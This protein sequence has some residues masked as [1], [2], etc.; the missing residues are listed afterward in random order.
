MQK[1]RVALALAASLLAGQALPAPRHDDARGCKPEKG[2]DDGRT[3]EVDCDAGGTIARALARM[4]PGDAL[5]VSGV[6]RENVEIGE[7]LHDVTVDGQGLAS[8]VPPSAALDGVRIYGDQVTIRGFTISG[9]RDVINLRGAMGTTIDGNTL[10]NGAGN[11]INVHR[12]SFALIVNNSI[13][14]NGQ[15]IMVFENSSARVGFRENT[16]AEANTIEGNRSHGVFVARSSNAAVANNLIARNAGNG[17]HIE[18]NSQAE[19]ASN[20]IDQNSASGVFVTQNSGANLGTPSGAGFLNL[21]NT[22]SVANAGFGFQCAAGAYVAGRLGTLN[23]GAGTRS[24]ASSCVD[25]VP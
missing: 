18:K 5:F 12:V 19:V 15:G 10:E 1:K 3:L 8:I 2:D 20:T 22:T 17:V 21:P 16:V 7:G 9:G 23:G 6:C 13:R 4:R 25:S 11:G 24:T 14:N